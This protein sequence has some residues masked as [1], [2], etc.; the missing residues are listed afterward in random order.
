MNL[1]SIDLNKVAVFC[2]V[3]DSGG[4]RRASVA[5][6]VTP[7]ALSQS[8]ATLEY[9]LGLK[10]FN[11]L[12]RKLV[13]TA[14]G[15]QLYRDFRQHHVG[16]LQALGDL[17]GRKDRI[18][19]LVN[20]GAYLEFAKSQLAP[21]IASF[22]RENPDVQTRLIFDTPS[23][24][25]E[26]LES[27]KL[28]LCFSIYPSIETR[29]IESKRVYHEELVLIAPKAQLSPKPSFEDVMSTPMI[30]YY[31]NHQPLK[32]WLALHYGRRP[33]TLPIRV[34]AS[35]AEMVFALVKERAGIGVVPRYLLGASE[36]SGPVTIVRPTPKKFMDHIW[37]LEPRTETKSLA[38]A[39]FSAYAAKALS[40][41][42]RA[43]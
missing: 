29:T 27:G 19:G 1:H 15:L 7:S 14:A 8:I 43:T 11:R 42:A 22:S 24:L 40:R 30:E 16:F 3:V 35:T 2:Q 21:L 12:G 13:P 41:S 5:L 28:D 26:R 34:Y 10:L 37:M 9:H 39:A 6:N 18:E 17:V 36:S 23:R 33:K 20:I 32:R 38:H 31:V 25:Q 4:Y